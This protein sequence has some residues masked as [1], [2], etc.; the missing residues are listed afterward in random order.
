MKSD[1]LQDTRIEDGGG[2]RIRR[3]KA[4]RE[5]KLATSE[6]LEKDWLFHPL[7]APWS[8]AGRSVGYL[9]QGRS[10]RRCQRRAP[11]RLVSR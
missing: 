10:I 7:Q 5:V 1:V 3:G 6:A 4:L 9:W 8:L 2:Q 11:G